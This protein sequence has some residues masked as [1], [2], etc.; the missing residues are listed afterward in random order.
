MGFCIRYGVPQPGRSVSRSILRDRP[1]RVLFSLKKTAGDLFKIKHWD[2]RL[3]SYGDLENQVATWFIDPP[4]SN[5]GKKYSFGSSM[6]D[7]AQLGAWCIGRSG[8][9]IV[10]EG[11]DADWLPFR[12]L[13][14]HQ[15]SGGPKKELVYSRDPYWI[16]KEIF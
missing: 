16:Q 11:G 7:Y 14:M 5:A 10:C 9:I 12:F 2:I 4:Y 1:N 15:G 6:I 13:K 8:D 3:G